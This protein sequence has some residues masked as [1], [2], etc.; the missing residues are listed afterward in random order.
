MWWQVHTH[1]H[2]DKIDG[3]FTHGLA[4]Q[5]VPRREHGNGERHNNGQDGEVGHGQIDDV[6]IGG[7][8]LPVSPH[9]VDDQA[10]AQGSQNDDAD[11]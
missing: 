5:P 2:K 9:G 10:V 11:P 1:T 8:P 3:G 7:W 4:V 6:E